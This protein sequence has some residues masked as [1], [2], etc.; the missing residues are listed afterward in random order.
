MPRHSTLHDDHFL[1]MSDQATAAQVNIYARDPDLLAA[2]Y[3]EMGMAE[4]F[5]FP[6]DGSPEHVEV[7]LGGLILGL[8]SRAAMERLADLPVE[9]GPPQSE[10]VIWCGDARALWRSACER[11][12]QPV[13]EPKAFNGRLLAAWAADPEGNRVKFV[14]LLN[15]A[16][17]TP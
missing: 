17:G 5:R 12:G 1:R 11:G 8:T 9:T 3:V 13:A 15:E 2:F 10:V 16:R 6:T 14:S 4:R 7:S